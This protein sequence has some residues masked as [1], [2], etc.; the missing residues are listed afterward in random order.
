MKVEMEEYGANVRVLVEMVEKAISIEFGDRDFGDASFGVTRLVLDVSEALAFAVAL[1]AF[2]E[3]AENRNKFC[4]E[5]DGEGWRS[6][7]EE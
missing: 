2:C 3:K 1:K 6:E 4:M 7:P 5:M